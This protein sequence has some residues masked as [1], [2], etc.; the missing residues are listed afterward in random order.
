MRELRIT[1]SAAY[2]RRE[3]K[4]AISLIARGLVKPFYK[5]YRLDEVNQAYEDILAGRLVG[6]AV[7]TP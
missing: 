1:G 2:T 4:A 5:T 7:I 6:R 3:Y